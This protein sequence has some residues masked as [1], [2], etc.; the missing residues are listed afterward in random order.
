VGHI[1]NYFTAMVLSVYQS[2][3]NVS[4]YGKFRRLWLTH[5]L[6]SLKAVGRRI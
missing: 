5:P 4:G 3:S 1:E 6:R 2:N